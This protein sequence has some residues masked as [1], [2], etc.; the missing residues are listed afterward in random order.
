[1]KKRYWLW[2]VVV[3]AAVAAALVAP[4]QWRA[5]EGVLEVNID[6]E[7][8]TL[9]VQIG[10]PSPL[11]VGRVTLPG[12]VPLSGDPIEVHIDAGG[13]TFE[14]LSVALILTDGSTEDIPLLTVEDDVVI[15]R[16]TAPNHADVVLALLAAVVVLWV[17]ELVPLHVA[18]LTVPIVL[19][20][21]DVAGARTALAPFADPIIILFFAGFLMAEAMKRVGLDRLIASRLVGLAGGGPARLFAAVLG[22]SAVLSMFMSNTAAVTVT[23]PIALAVTAPVADDGFRRAVVLGLAY[24]ATVG[25]VGSA[26]GTPANPLAITFLHEVVGRDINFV[27][28]F[29]FGLPVVVL[30]LPIVGVWVWWRSNVSVDP[31]ELAAVRQAAGEE[32]LAAGTLTKDQIQVLLV[33][34]LVVAG[35]LT[36]TWHDTS[37]AIVALGGAVVLMGIGKIETEDLGRIAWPTLLTFGG[38]LALGTALVLSGTS[39]W[40]VT[41]LSG[42]ADLP[43]SLALLVVVGGTM[44]FTAVASNTASAATLIP[45]AI[46]LA[47]VVGLDPVLVVCLVAAASSIDFAL[48]VG[49]PPTMLAYDTG[50]FTARRV[51]SVGIVLDIAGVI[52]LALV[53]T[54][55]WRAFGLVA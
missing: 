34:G 38:G 36:Q 6:D 40:I 9:D 32:Q 45:F 35:W 25:G 51:F 8:V 28:W 1:M 43:E 24:A 54:Q 39:D 18:G 12:G 11:Q 22:V 47:G 20:L 49:T 48:V 17:T 30:L 4:P 37:P 14:D 46:P 29:A 55:V 13:S 53:V 44:A 7:V 50:L 52:V 33:F 5:G 26:I 10:D 27:E 31:S 23:M 15:A 2:L 19:V 41:R 3:A 16:R 42:L 21:G